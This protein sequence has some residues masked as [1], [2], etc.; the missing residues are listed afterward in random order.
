MP[1]LERR[2]LE[3]AVRADGASGRRMSGYAIVYDSPANLFDDLDEVCRFPMCARALRENQDI[4][5]LRDHNPSQIIGRSTISSGPGRLQVTENTAGLFFICDVVNTDEGDTTLELV[6][7]GLL[8]G[9]S[10]S[11]RVIKD[12]WTTTR[13]PVTGKSRDLREL[14]DVDLFDISPVTYPTYTAT[15]VS[16]DSAMSASAGRMS[17]LFPAGVLPATMPIELR[18]RVQSSMSAAPR[19]DPELQ[20]LIDQQLQ[21]NARITRG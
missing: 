9:C 14:L 6:R 18:S 4:R 15:T 10:F 19:L 21:H 11:F 17:A 8:T 5:C 20:H 16:A 7:A 3:R 1:E 2:F 13:D 12:R